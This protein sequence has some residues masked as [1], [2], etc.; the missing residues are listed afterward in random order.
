MM[1]EL[2][3]FSSASDVV[4]SD[5]KIGMWVVGHWIDAHSTWDTVQISVERSEPCD[6]AVRNIQRR[7]VIWD[8]P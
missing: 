1:F 3:E 7:G 5:M 2:A 4:K 8:G 6:E